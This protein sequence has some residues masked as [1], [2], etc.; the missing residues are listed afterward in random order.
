MRVTP[1]STACSEAQKVETAL[2]AGSLSGIHDIILILS[3]GLLPDALIWR[4][5]FWGQREE[6]LRD[7]FGLLGPR[8][9]LYLEDSMWVEGCSVLA[10]WWSGALRDLSSLDQGLNPCP[11]Q[12][13]CGVLT[14]EQPGKFLGVYLPLA[15]MR[16]CEVLHSGHPVTQPSQAPTK[17]LTTSGSWITQF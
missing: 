12:W 13:K 10:Q 11:L 17:S 6:G 16:P 9:G 3:S 8:S 15:T 7:L 1:I 14:M 2:L 5:G 4:T